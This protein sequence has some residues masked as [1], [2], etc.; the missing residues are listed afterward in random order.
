RKY[1]VEILEKA[2]MV[3]CN[4]SRIRVDTESKLGDVCLYMHD[5]WE[6]HFSALKRILRYVR[7]TLDHGLQL[8]SSS[9]TSLVAYSDANWAGLPCYSD[10][11]FSAK[12]EYRGVANAVAETCWPRTLL[13]ELHTSLSSAT[14]VYC[15]NVSVVYLSSNSVQHQ[16]TKHIE[17]DIHFV[18]DLVVAGQELF[19]IGQWELGLMGMCFGIGT[20]FGGGYY[21]VIRNL[22]GTSYP[23][24]VW[25]AVI[26]ISRG[27]ELLVG[28]G[29][30][31]FLEEGLGNMGNFIPGEMDLGMEV[32]RAVVGVIGRRWELVLWIM[33]D[34]RDSFRNHRDVRVGLS[35]WKGITER[36]ACAIVKETDLLIGTYWSFGFVDRARLPRNLFAGMELGT[37]IRP[38]SGHRGEEGSG[39]P[40]CGRERIVGEWEPGIGE[41]REVHFVERFVGMMGFGSI[42]MGSR[43]AER[44]ETGG[45]I[46]GVCNA[47]G[48]SGL[49]GVG[50]NGGGMEFLGTYWGG[51]ALS[52][53]ECIGHKFLEGSGG[54]FGG[55]FWKT[56]WIGTSEECFS[57]IGWC[58]GWNG[59]VGWRMGNGPEGLELFL[60][61]KKKNPVQVRDGKKLGLT[62]NTRF[63]LLELFLG[64]TVMGRSSYFDVLRNGLEEEMGSGGYSP[65]CGIGDGGDWNLVVCWWGL[66]R[67]DGDLF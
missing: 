38:F 44:M 13:R 54:I 8:F 36:G 5:P 26:D 1:A 64:G 48:V 25:V 55:G 49:G 14:L 17:I 24:A 51:M 7:G 31:D 2:R 60:W 43:M 23:C 56:G 33:W 47:E 41:W 40:D 11:N 19:L 22:W 52:L 63:H 39:Y 29:F 30:V 34:C 28:M 18:R 3:N 27:W 67:A 46:D 12:A 53:E 15:D 35:V 62:R 10:V 4:P 9:T 6:P 42:Y 32:V 59:Y 61:G 57:V 65:M 20:S 50:R 21:R 58:F 37:G 45:R 16:C 66:R